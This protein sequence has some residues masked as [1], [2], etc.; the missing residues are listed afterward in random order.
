MVLPMRE[1]ALKYM[2]GISYDWWQYNSQCRLITPITSLLNSSVDLEPYLGKWNAHY[3]CEYI[4]KV[5]I[6]ELYRYAI[7]SRSENDNTLGSTEAFRTG[8]PNWAVQGM[9]MRMGPV[10][11]PKPFKTLKTPARPVRYLYQRRMAPVGADANS[12]TR[13]QLC[14]G[15]KSFGAH[16][17]M[18]PYKWNRESYGFLHHAFRTKKCMADHNLGCLWCGATDASL[19]SLGLFLH[20]VQCR[21]NAV[22][23]SPNPHN[24]HPIASPRGRAM[25][26]LLWF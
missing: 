7:T 5:F 1:N 18:G 20:T 16:R 4:I 14:K 25:G 10:L 23:L 26:C 11:C 24:R 15:I 9:G 17:L 3:I 8:P 19:I 12:L 13:K 22:N 21:Y 6:I 2:L